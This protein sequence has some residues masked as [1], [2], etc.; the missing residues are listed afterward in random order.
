M[1]LVGRKGLKPMKTDVCVGFCWCQQGDPSV[2]DWKIRIGCAGPKSNP[3]CHVWFD[4]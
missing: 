2:L 1:V 3:V 4:W